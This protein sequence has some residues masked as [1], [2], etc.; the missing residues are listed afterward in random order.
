[1]SA[2]K[3]KLTTEKDKSSDLESQ[4]LN[5]EEDSNK[6]RREKIKLQEEN[7]RFRRLMANSHSDGTASQSDMNKLIK[8]Y[9]SMLKENKKLR[10][11]IAERENSSNNS[12]SVFYAN[13]LQPFQDTNHFNTTATSTKAS[14]L[15]HVR[16]EYDHRVQKLTEE[17]RELIRQR[18]TSDISLNTLKQKYNSVE[19]ELVLARNEI[20]TLNLAL[21]QNK[22]VGDNNNSDNRL[23]S[24]KNPKSG[25]KNKTTST[26]YSRLNASNARRALYPTIT[27]MNNI[28]ESKVSPIPDLIIKD[29]VAVNKS[30]NKENIKY[31]SNR[32][33]IS[34]SK[35]RNI[36]TPSNHVKLP[37]NENKYHFNAKASKRQAIATGSSTGNNDNLVQRN[38]NNRKQPTLVDLSKSTQPSDP[39][40]CKQS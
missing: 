23:S 4:N 8:E 28:N 22:I 37:N 18:M 1:M 10:K 15:S 3:R 21:E 31:N 33:N 27:A 19:E 20:T 40:E 9:D 38:I 39:G 6:L 35:S 13:N 12:N 24:N 2:L 32:N 29:T 5:L 34:F 16:N 26:N 11:E 36:G 17:K 7:D 25:N 14:T 30:I